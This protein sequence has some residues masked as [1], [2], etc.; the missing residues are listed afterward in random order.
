MRQLTLKLTYLR[1]LQQKEQD[2]FLK[3]VAKHKNEAHY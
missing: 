3:S 2:E 1:L